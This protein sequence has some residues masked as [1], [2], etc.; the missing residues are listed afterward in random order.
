[1]DQGFRIQISNRAGFRIQIWYTGIRK[2]VFLFGCYNVE[3]ALAITQSPLSGP[4]Y[5]YPGRPRLSQT[6]HLTNAENSYQMSSPGKGRLTWLVKVIFII[7]CPLKKLWR[8][9][10]ASLRNL[11]PLEILGK[12]QQHHKKKSLNECRDLPS[13]G[14][15]WKICI[16]MTFFFNEVNLQFTF[17][18]EMTWWNMSLLFL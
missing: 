8:N 13:N 15:R 4:F 3:W 10:K 6:K 9:I 11:G 17:H 12:H 5:K 18:I 14:F 2:L 16:K 1:M 7:W